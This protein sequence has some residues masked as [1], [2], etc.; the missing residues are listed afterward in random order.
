MLTTFIFQKKLYMETAIKK[1]SQQ[2]ADGNFKNTY[3][4]MS[5][6]IE[7]KIF[8]TTHLRGKKEVIA[9][10]E[11]MCNDMADATVNNISYIEQD[12]TVAVQGYFNCLKADKNPG[13]FEY[14]EVYLFK[15]EKLC[16]IKTYAVEVPL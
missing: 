7:W 8:G 3:N 2:F 14:C 5:E 4:D 10:C 15:D 9:F 12:N 11:K 1:I 6:D 16:D 13:K